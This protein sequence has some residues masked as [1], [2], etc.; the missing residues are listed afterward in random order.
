[1]RLRRATQPALLVSIR[2][3]LL[4]LQ[5]TQRHSLFDPATAKEQ[6]RGSLQPRSLPS[7]WRGI[8]GHSLPN[9]SKLQNCRQYREH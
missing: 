7:S 3:S 5:R 4:Q 9:I 1:M 6:G 2:H 8:A